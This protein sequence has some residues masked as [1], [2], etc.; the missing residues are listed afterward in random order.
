MLHAPRPCVGTQGV[1]LVRRRCSAGLAAPRADLSAL[2][3]VAAAATLRAGPAGRSCRRRGP[4]HGMR[5]AVPSACGEGRR[6]PRARSRTGMAV[7]EGFEPSVGLLRSYNGL[8]NRRLQPLGHLTVSKMLRILRVS[9]QRL[10][11]PRPTV[12]KTVPTRPAAP[13]LESSRTTIIAANG[14]AAPAHRARL[15]ICSS[16]PAPTTAPP[17]G[18]RHREGHR[19]SRC[20]TGRTRSASCGR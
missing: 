18:G 2:Q 9:R 7:R 4:H 11:R 15:T 19:H 1:G 12:P 20:C 17:G 10:S 16:L 6:E 13:L 5:S 3:A 8:A 14:P